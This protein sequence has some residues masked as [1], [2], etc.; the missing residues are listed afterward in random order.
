MAFCVKEVRSCN[1]GNVVSGVCRISSGFYKLLNKPCHP[2]SSVG[3]EHLCKKPRAVEELRQIGLRRLAALQ[4]RAVQRLTP[5][6]RPSLDPRPAA[7]A[8]EE[9][10]L[11]ISGVTPPVFASNTNLLKR[12]SA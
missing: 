9:D 10:F 2:P 7:Q 5:E 6:N 8:C 3:C 4:H 12:L 1:V 11:E